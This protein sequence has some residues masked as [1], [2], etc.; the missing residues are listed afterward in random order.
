AIKPI[1]PQWA[2]LKEHASRQGSRRD[3][4]TVLTY[5]KG[6]LLCHQTAFNQECA[7]ASESLQRL[8]IFF[9]TWY[10]F[11]LQ[12]VLKNDVHYCSFLRNNKLYRQYPCGGIF[13]I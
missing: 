6:R 3:Q 12:Q 10:T 1:Q 8:P 13:T 7:T 5:S 4:L 11:L 9:H 2:V